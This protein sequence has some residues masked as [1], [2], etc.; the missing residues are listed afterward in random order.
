LPSFFLVKGRANVF[1]DHLS[2]ENL[3]HLYRGSASGKRGEAPLL[4][5]ALALWL[6]D[7]EAQGFSKK[8][9]TERRGFVERFCWWLEHEAKL[10]VSL[11]SLDASPPG[12]C[13]R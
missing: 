4:R 2:G 5:E 6:G 11:D 8:T 9:V 7:C 10:P 13:G 3:A 12:R 1:V